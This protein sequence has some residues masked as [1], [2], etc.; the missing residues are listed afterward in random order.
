VRTF[1]E[2]RFADAE[3][4]IGMQ[5]LTSGGDRIDVAFA[6]DTD[7]AELLR[8][9]IEETPPQEPRL[10]GQLETVLRKPKRDQ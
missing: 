9:L 2:I 7:P 6:N 4:P 10:L 1:K 8:Q 5:M 3:A